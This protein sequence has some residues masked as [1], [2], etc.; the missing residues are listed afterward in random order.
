[1]SQP[2]LQTRW[3]GAVLNVILQLCM[4]NCAGRLL[5]VGPSQISHEK[6]GQQMAV[7]C[8]GGFLVAFA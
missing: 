2:D 7:S 4:T 6:K 1:M 8:R 3:M 5:G